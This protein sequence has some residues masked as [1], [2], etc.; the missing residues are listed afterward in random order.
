MNE[1]EAINA[2]SSASAFLVSCGLD[3]TPDAISQLT[4]A[5]LP[6][7]RVMI[8]RGYD[9]NG[10]TWREAGWRG[11]LNE[12]RKKSGRLWYRSWKKREFDADSAIDIM[13][14]AG[15]YLRMENEGEPFGGVGEPDELYKMEIPE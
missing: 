3:P 9:P 13:N 5:F 7:L 15:F 6:C 14:Y 11:L 12:I 1:S 10:V 2:R 8:E 4:E